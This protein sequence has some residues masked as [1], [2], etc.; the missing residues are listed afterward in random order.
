MVPL[1]TIDSGYLEAGFKL[2][3]AVVAVVPPLLAWAAF[4]KKNET[5]FA[6]VGSKGA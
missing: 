6:N 4:K 5:E 2:I 1:V 3:A